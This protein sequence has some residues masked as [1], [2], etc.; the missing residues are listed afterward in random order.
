MSADLKA[1]RVLEFS[2]KQSEWDPWSEKFLARAK[3]N[4][5]KD[6][7]IGKTPIPTKVELEAAPEGEELTKTL[8]KKSALNEQAYEDM[9][10]SINT[11]KSSGRVAFSLVKNCKSDEY[12]EGNCKSA[13]DRLFAKYAPKSVPSLLKMKREFAN[14]RLEEEYTHPES[15][16]ASL[17]N[18]RNDMDVISSSIDESTKMSDLD[19]MIHVINNLHESYDV[20]LDGLENR[21]MLKKGDPQKLTL[22]DLRAKLNGQY[23]RI[24][25]REKEKEKKEIVLDTA[26]SAQLGRQFKG[27]CN[28]CGKYGHKGDSPLCPENELKCYYCGKAS[29]FKRDCELLKAHKQGQGEKANVVIDDFEFQNFDF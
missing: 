11:A 20:I 12:P 3:R 27:I 8:K 15:W 29:H 18:I 5:Y 28:K 16:I 10:L 7:L 26:L 22:E 6:L 24:E 13:W 4:G 17:E 9:I 25:E 1:I 2:G 19:F 21:L 14:S 23:E